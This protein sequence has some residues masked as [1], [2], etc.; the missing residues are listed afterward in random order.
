MINEILVIN[1][2]LEINGELT[3]NERLVFHGLIVGWWSIGV[4]QII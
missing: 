2:R 1:E 4:L 3:L